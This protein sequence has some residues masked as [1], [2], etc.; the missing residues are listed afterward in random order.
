MIDQYRVLVLGLVMITYSWLAK[1]PI[2]SL[3]FEEW[4]IFLIAHLQEELPLVS[5][6]LLVVE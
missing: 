4:E 5:L 6:L 2:F 3:R 1:E